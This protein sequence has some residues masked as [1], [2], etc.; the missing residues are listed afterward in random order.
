MLI[1]RAHLGPRTES[2][3][4][5]LGGV[6]ACWTQARTNE[7]LLV[8]AAPSQAVSARWRSRAFQLRCHDRPALAVAQFPPAGGSARL[9]SGRRQGLLSHRCPLP[10]SL[11]TL[12]HETAKHECEITYRTAIAA[13]CRARAAG[14]CFDARWAA[15]CTT[16]SRRAGAYKKPRL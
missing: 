13:I 14:V 8:R 3:T 7:T 5:S 10:A 4:A 9:G 1:R 11:A 12:P 16:L 15:N 2:K 6:G